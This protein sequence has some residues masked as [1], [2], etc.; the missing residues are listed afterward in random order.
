M[1]S[2]KRG[3]KAYFSLIL[4]CVMLSGEMV[5][6]MA[7]ELPSFGQYVAGDNRVG[8]SAAEGEYTVITIST[9]EELALLA[10]DCRLDSWSQDKYV[11]LANDI[12]L[13]E[14]KGIM[15]PSFSGVFDGGGY[16]ISGLELDSAGSV[17]GLFRYV[18]KGG[19]IRHLS[20]QGRLAPVGSKSRIGMIAG[21]NY[22]KVFDC[23]VYG[24]VSGAEEVGGIVGVNGPGG[25]IRRCGSFAIVTGDHCTGGIC[26]KNQGV[27]NNCE[28][29]GNINTYSQ[30]VPLGIED[31]TME[32]LEELND[33]QTIRAHT[34]T[35]GI[36][37]YSEGKIYYCSNTGVVGYQHVGYNTGG[38]VGR[39]HQGYLQNCSNAGHVLGRKDVGG[40]V[41]QME[42]F[43]EVQYLSDKLSEIDRE[44][45]LFFQLLEASHEDL[46]R[47]SGEAVDLTRQISVNLTNASNAAGELA[48]AA[49]DVWYIYNQELTGIGNDLDRLNQEW[50]DLAEADK[51]EDNTPGDGGIK[52]PDSGEGGIKLPG[53]GDSDIKL[54]D[55]GDGELNKTEQGEQGPELLSQTE[56]FQEN[57]V[58][59]GNSVYNYTPGQGD[60]ALNGNHT[61]P[62]NPVINGSNANDGNNSF[63]D[64]QFPNGNGQGNNNQNGSNA[65]LPDQWQGTQNWDI[66]EDLESYFAALRRFGEGTSNHLNNMTSAAND[67]SGGIRENLETLNRELDAAGNN[68][69]RL[70]DVLADGTDKTSANVDALMQQGKVLRRTINELRDDLFRYEGISVEDASDEAAGTEVNEAAGTEANEPE[71]SAEE[72]YYDT[73]TFQQGKIT[74]CVNSGPVE[75]DTNVGG[76]VGQVAT[77]YDF[78]PEDD[79]TFSGE[80]SFNIEQTIKAIVRESRNLGDIQGKKDYVGGIVG[81]G[82]YG[83]VISCES[84]GAV[85]ST[86]GSYVGGVVGSSGYCVRS[87]YFLGELSGK[88][89]VG[90][91][92]G[93]GCDIFYSY[94]YPEVAYTGEYAGSIAGQ[95]EEEGILCGNYY[96]SNDA[97]DNV[98]PGVD[99]IGYTGGAEPLAYADFCA[100]PEVPRAFT[101][102]TISF[103]AE[104]QELLSLRCHYGEAIDRSLIP[105][106]PAKEGFYGTWPEFDWDYVT[107]NKML[108]AQYEKW[109][110]S[111][112]SEEKDENGKTR[113][114]AQG[115]FLPEARLTLKDTREGTQ[116]A[117]GYVDENGMLNG[118]YEEPIHVRVLWENAPEDTMVEVW[119]DGNYRQVPVEVM[120]SYLAFAMERPGT[121]RLITAEEEDSKILLM[122]GAAGAVVI[123]L[124]LLSKAIGRHRQKK[125]PDHSL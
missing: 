24:S 94:A 117:I 38:I 7:A 56:T 99:S 10:Q 109:I 118:T 76:I 57:M 35:G 1:K 79:I 70:A 62:E 125:A 67:R 90:G 77:E 60:N 40:I 52:L 53:S 29:V 91:I 92:V 75:A 3:Y 32:N 119:E 30:D 120:G 21:V 68:M 61:I 54:P 23:N 112:A 104:G 5:P 103:R 100:R 12:V 80:E 95:V 66:R 33:A 85:S 41:G 31:I 93:K 88:N 8:I 27:I 59:E 13:E 110:T 111:L 11:K 101:E 108:E 63:L 64:Q 6:V 86:G 122:A 113:L 45:D 114:L 78:D 39:L 55:S 20:V 43:L 71:V 116:I 26:G 28:N 2:D 25:E 72:G 73:A 47:Y 14:H 18:Q 37:G 105:E 89:N 50:G 42:P 16:K 84:Y 124:L 121:F 51:N 98:L 107:G 49:M 97:C 106:V 19:V 82:D 69:Q 48:E 81:R 46:S 102:F 9:E 58:Q 96:V 123:I 36:A 4:S 74:L 83:A 65:G 22:G 44:T 17:A 87:C 34:D 115:K 15:I